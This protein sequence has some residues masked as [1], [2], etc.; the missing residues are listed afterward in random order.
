MRILITGGA[1][2]IGSHV[3]EHLVSAGEDICIIDSLDDSYDVRLKRANLAAMEKVGPFRFV[4]ADICDEV[5][6]ARVVD[7]F[8]PE[9]VVH[10]AAL[11]GVRRSLS[12][13]IRYEHVNVRGTLILLEACRRTATRKF[14]LASSSAVYGNAREIPFRVED[15]TMLPISPY[16][17]TKIAAE[18]LCFTY[19]HLYGIGMSCLRFFTVYGPRQR[20]DLAIRKFAQMI[21]EGAPIPVFGDGSTARDYTYVDDIVRGVIAALRVDHA[22]EVFNLGS[23]HPVTICRMIETLEDSL[24]KRAV[25]NHMPTQPG[26]V[27]ITFADISKSQRLLG[28][29]PD[30]TFETGIRKFVDWFC[31]TREI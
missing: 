31:A 30:V 26:D 19:S 1:G 9:A 14:V 21:V 16:A 18:K 5:G 13:P 17:A 7:D 22:Y 25:V 24:G 29:S 15:H 28:Y 11:T 2:F 8:S 12:Q 23:T 6:V 4:E 10:L 20:P 3:C 27:S